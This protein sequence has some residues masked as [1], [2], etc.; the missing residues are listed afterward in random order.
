MDD[1]IIDAMSR[2]I[3]ITQGCDP[4]R[5]DGAPGW[6]LWM[7]YR[8]EARAVLAALCSEPVLSVLV[9]RVDEN[10]QGS[11]WRMLDAESIANIILAALTPDEGGTDPAQPQSGGEQSDGS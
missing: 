10:Y 7:S 11:G 8:N 5:E 6:L 4:D 3:C 2:A 1:P 9:R